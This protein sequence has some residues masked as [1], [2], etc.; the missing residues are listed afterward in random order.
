[1]PT[2]RLYCLG[3]KD[4]VTESHWVEASTDHEA[5]EI[6]KVEH[7][8]SRCELWLGKRLIAYFGELS[9]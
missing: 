3:E 4:E 8:G 2:Y 6:V 1:M 9:S 5:I 7:R